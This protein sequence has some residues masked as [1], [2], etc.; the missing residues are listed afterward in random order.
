MSLSISHQRLGLEGGWFELCRPLGFQGGNKNK[1]LPCG[2]SCFNTAA[3]P[4]AKIKRRKT[5]KLKPPPHKKTK[6]K[7]RKGSVSSS[8]EDL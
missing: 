6:G 4:D 5:L 2:L 1:Y 3:R 7:K 8:E